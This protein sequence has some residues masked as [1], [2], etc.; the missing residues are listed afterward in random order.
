MGWK[1]GL[2]RTLKNSA[3]GY[4]ANAQ[5]FASVCRIS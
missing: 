1:L 2:S 5:A 4:Q 3:F